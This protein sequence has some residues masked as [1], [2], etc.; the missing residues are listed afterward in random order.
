VAGRVTI[1]PVEAAV[2]AQRLAARGG[3]IESED[4]EFDPAWDEALDI[5]D[6]QGTR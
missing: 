4:G 2:Q 3:G 6:V 5:Q 1:F